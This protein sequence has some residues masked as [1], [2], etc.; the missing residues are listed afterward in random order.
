MNCPCG[1]NLEFKKCC[2]PFLNGEKHPDTAEKLMRARYSAYVHTNID[3]L[4]KTLAP[5]SKSD[6]DPKSAKQWAKQAQWLG[7]KINSTE[8][9]GPTDK[10]GTVEFT[11]TY[12]QGSETL[13]HHEVSKFRKADNDHWFFVDGESHTHKAGE[14]HHHAKPETVVREQ[15]KVGRN[16]ACPCGSGK[17]YKKCCGFDA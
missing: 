5:E 11:A 7:L 10:T 6:F 2:E 3:Y 8:F 9:G 14:G 16:D 15:P 4:Q 13:D 17:K 1:S 12:K